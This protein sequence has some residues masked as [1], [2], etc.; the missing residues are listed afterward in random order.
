MSFVIVALLLLV[1]AAA[2]AYPLL[3]GRTPSAE[4]APVV[5]DGDIERALRDL[6]WAR[7][8]ESHS[9]PACGQGYEAGDRFCV[10]CGGALPQAENPAPV[11][12]CPSCG[13]AV[14][15]GDE[16]CAKCGHSIQVGGTA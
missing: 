16:F 4:V 1:A 15:E 6:R 12:V 10:R 2:I 9:C 3:P 5:T 11:P 14:R 8:R 13:A 7:R